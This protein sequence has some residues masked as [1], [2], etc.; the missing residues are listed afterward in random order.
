MDTD[1]D[2]SVAERIAQRLKSFVFPRLRLYGV[3]I[4]NVSHLY[5]LVCRICAA[6]VPALDQ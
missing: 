1:G 3:H 5:S 4:G 6:A 2:T